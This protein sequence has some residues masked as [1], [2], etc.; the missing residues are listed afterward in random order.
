MRYLIK[1]LAV[2]FLFISASLYS[3][4]K[5]EK[6]RKEENPQIIKESVGFN[7]TIRVFGKRGEEW[8]INGKEIRIREGRVLLKEVEI[9]SGEGYRILAK[10]AEFFRDRNLSILEGDVRLMGE[11]L[12]VKSERA[13]IY[14]S[15]GY[16]KGG[17]RVE[18]WRGRNYV[19]GKTFIAFF[20]PLRVIIE[21]VKTRHE[22]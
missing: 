17:R 10:T 20:S 14:F 6:I 4:Y 12:F 9:I 3:I 15:E 13:E 1:T 18:V 2:I 5:V 8:N 11:A 22:L 7:V 16:M 19:E 21:N